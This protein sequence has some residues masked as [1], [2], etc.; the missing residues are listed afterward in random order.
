MSS[1]FPKRERESLREKFDAM[2]MEEG[3][4]IVQYAS[5]IKEVVS[6]IRSANGFLDDENVNRKFLRTLLPIYAIRVSAMQ[7]LRCIPGTKLSVEGIVGRLI[8]F[9]LSN[10]DK[11]IP[12]NLEYIFKAKLF[13]KDI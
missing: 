9:E 13:L 11:Y 2:R 10:F 3:E 8:A 5:K 7:E 4:N 6:A 12:K 1:K